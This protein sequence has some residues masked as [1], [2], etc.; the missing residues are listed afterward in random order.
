MESV[1]IYANWNLII[2]C[3]ATVFNPPLNVLM[4][5]DW[6]GKRTEEFKASE[7]KLM[8]GATDCLNSFFQFVVLETQDLRHGKQAASEL[9]IPRH[10]SFL[11]LIQLREEPTWD[12]PQHGAWKSTE[13][14]PG[15][16][17]CFPHKRTPGE[18]TSER[19]LLSPRLQTKYSLKEMDVRRE[20]DSWIIS[21]F[22][23]QCLCPAHQNNSKGNFIIRLPSCS[24]LPVLKVRKIQEI[25]ASTE[26]SSGFSVIN[27]SWTF[28]SHVPFTSFLYL[29]LPQSLC[30]FHRPTPIL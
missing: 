13:T 29:F 25:K 2:S 22:L 12:S 17:M 19:A 6:T 7:W 23:S 30:L 15:E 14:H 3:R 18:H 16:Q 27:S 26:S 4:P 28:K 20:K 10:A 9:H 8:W 11:V 24:V 5:G 21:R 1:G